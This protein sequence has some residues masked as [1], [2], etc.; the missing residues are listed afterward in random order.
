MK[1]RHKTVV[2]TLI[3]CLLGGSMFLGGCALRQDQIVKDKNSVQR[4]AEINLG[5]GPDTVANIAKQA[6]PA[7]VK[8]DTLVQNRV[9]PNDPFLNNPFFRNFFG[10]QP[11]RQLQ[12]ELGSGFIIAKDG[13]ILTNNHVVEGA[14][15]ITITLKGNKQEYTGRVVGAD[16]ELDLA[17]L[18]INAG[19]N[20]PALALG[21]SDQIKVGNWV[22]AIGSPYGLEDTVTVGVISAKGRPVQIGN[23]RFRN[24]LQTDASIN[25]GN[26]GGPLLNLQGQV[27]GINT[28]INAQAQGIGFAIPSSTVKSVL[29][30]LIKSKA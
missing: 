7:V 2:L 6:G 17:V 4:G 27:I 16:Q 25:P 13:Y 9:R 12:R 15:K 3:L 1:S 11:Q 26:S 14:Q 19:N 18:K 8:V 22:V 5:V 10:A 29:N 28:A 30:K 21:D 20:L 23:S 24:L